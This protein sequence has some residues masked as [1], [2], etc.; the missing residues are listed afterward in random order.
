MPTL[1]PT[2]PVLPDDADRVVVDPAR[3]DAAWVQ[4]VLQD[5]GVVGA[6][7]VAAVK[8]AATQASTWSRLT[9]ISVHYR[10]GTPGVGTT[11]PS[12]LLL[13][14]CGAESGEFSRSEVDYYRRDYL[15]AAA[16]PLPRCFDAAF[17][18]HPRR[19]HLLL[20]DLSA[21]HRTGDDTPPDLAF[22]LALADALAA[23]HAH[24]WGVQRLQPIGRAV[25]GPAEIDRYLAHITPGLAPLMNLAGAALPAAWASRLP[26]LVA[27]LPDTFKARARD[28]RGMTLVHGDLNPGNLLVP[29]AGSGPV[30]LID[31]QPFDWSL[32]AW[33]GASD[34]AGALVPW[35]GSA[36]RSKVQGP[37][38]TRYHAGL[39]ARGVHDYPWV[40][41]LAD[42]RLGVLMSLLVPVEWC[43]LPTDR[44]R[45]RWLWTQQLQRALAALDD[46][47][48]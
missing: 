35:W 11:A 22:G 19:Y 39:V 32:T 34:L 17:A 37:V 44:E 33:L 10:S 28:A 23:L 1:R 43:V 25:A 15:G 13:K 31:R 12:A 5:V 48:A 18:E 38:L 21:S 45:M 7:A 3:I 16:A 20:E 4:Q 30:L 8:V 9:R 14:R 36:L 41:L 40:Q 46:L 47:P 26:G 27:G 29:R 2:M 24:R 42:W 6:G